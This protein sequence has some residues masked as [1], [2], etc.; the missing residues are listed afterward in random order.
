MLAIG[1]DIWKDW[2]KDTREQERAE[3]LLRDEMDTNVLL[4]EAMLRY[5]KLDTE[6]AKEQRLALD[7]LPT[8]PVDAWQAIRQSGAFSPAAS[9]VWKDIAATYHKIAVLNQR[10][11]ARELFKATSQALTR[12]AEQRG[13]LNE[14]LRENSEEILAR[15]KEHR[16]MLAGSQ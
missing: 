9:P 12:F 3:L 1:W 11:Q 13:A 6:A 10:I 4:L 7:A 2:R 5:L 8:L 14:T 15:L 16:K